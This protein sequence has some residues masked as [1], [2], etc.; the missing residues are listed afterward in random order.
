MLR[1][2]RSGWSGCPD[3][4][5]CGTAPPSDPSA[6]TTASGYGTDYGATVFMEKANY[7][8]LRALNTTSGPATGSAWIYYAESDLALW[9]SKWQKANIQVGGMTMNNQPI[10]AT[11]GNQVCV[12]SRPFVW[13]PPQF[14]TQS[15][16]DH[17]CVVSWMDD[18]P[19][20]DPSWTPLSDIPTFTV[21]DDLVDFILKHPNMGWRNT[22]D[23]SGLGPQWSQTIA[24]TGPVAGGQFQVGVQWHNMPTDGGTISY[25]IPGGPDGNPPPV[26]TKAI[27]IYASD[28]AP[29][30]PV[31]WPANFASSISITYTQGETPPPKGAYIAPA[32]NLPAD[33]MRASTL[34][35][36]RELQPGGF[37]KV[38]VVDA[39]GRRVGDEDEVFCI[40]S[41][42][43]R[44]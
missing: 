11:E 17:Y 27:P 38:E 37:R 35:L 40:G 19:H 6:F 29:M 32:V 7:V 4:I 36:A 31:T 34:R 30:T 23:V 18:P 20:E 33:Q 43:Y 42:P 26:N 14:Q 44:F 21:F 3:I 13:T 10:V 12:T 28:A 1:Q 16:D 15:G 39:L 5:L 24:I 9:P 22:V 25:S 41:T 8:Y 2:D